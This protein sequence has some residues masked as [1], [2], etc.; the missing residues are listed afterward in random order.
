MTQVGS[1]TVSQAVPQAPVASFT[2]NVTSGN[3]PLTVQLNDQSSNAPT[4]WNWSFGD[5]NSSNSQD[6]VYTYYAPGTYNVSLTAT[7]AGGSNTVTQAGYI[8]VYGANF[9]ANYLTGNAPLIVKFT[10]TSVG[11]T[12][13]LWNFGDGTTSTS[14]DPLHSFADAWSYNVTL[15][16]TTPGGVSTLDKYNYINI[17]LPITGNV[18][19]PLDLSMADLNNYTQVSIAN[20]TYGTSG[21]FYQMWASGASL[22]DILNRSMV[23]SGASSVTFYGSDG[24]YATVLLSQIRADNQS[25][26]SCAWYTN[27]PSSQGGDNQTE[28]D[29]IPSQTYGEEW[30]YGLTSIE[31]M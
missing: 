21:V 6:P 24:F 4:S 9:T 1:V 22:N 18:A 29:I 5:G 30:V 25:M 13:W 19:N 15:T 17:L 7:N 11:A 16:V 27:N 12:S 26:I 14:Q 28:R 31:V 3:V 23:N 2:A 8:T 20:H 10:D